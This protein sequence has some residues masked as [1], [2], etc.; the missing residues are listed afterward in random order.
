MSNEELKLKLSVIISAT[1]TSGNQKLDAIMELF[2]QLHPSP[3]PDVTEAVE[4][5][6]FIG[7]RP[8]PE[9]SKSTKL[10]RWWDND[11]RQYKFANTEELYSLFKNQKQ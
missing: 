6:N 11:T 4:F 10:W 7:D 8:L 1:N 9:Y 3:T 5:A 2:N